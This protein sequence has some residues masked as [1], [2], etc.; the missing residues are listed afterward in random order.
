[1][2]ILKIARLGHPILYKKAVPVDNV[3]DINITKLI[4]YSES[5]PY[6]SY[7]AE[8]YGPIMSSVQV[9]VCETGFKHKN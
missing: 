4:G 7:E 6:G 5:T 8:R 2:S 9:H 3:T 1:M